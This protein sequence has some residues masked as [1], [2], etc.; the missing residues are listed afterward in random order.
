MPILI[1]LVPN[2]TAIGFVL[3]VIS[4]LVANHPGPI[5]EFIDTYNIYADIPRWLSVSIYLAFIHTPTPAIPGT[6]RTF[7]GNKDYKMA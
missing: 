4:G 5:G 1:D 3:G 7:S 6:K 2:I